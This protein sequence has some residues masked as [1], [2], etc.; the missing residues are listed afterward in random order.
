MI[1]AVRI[2]DH[3]LVG[4]AELY[5]G[6][7]WINDRTGVT[8]CLGGVHPGRGTCNALLSLG[9]K[10]Y[11]EI[12]VPDPE[13]ESNHFT[14][15]LRSLK[16]PTLIT[17]AAATDSI[18]DVETMARD[19]GFHPESPRDGS[20]A[21]PDGKLLQWKSISING[22]F[23]SRF[24]EP[25]PFFIQ[26]LPGSSHP[27]QD[28]PAGCRLESLEFEDPDSSPL[29]A[30]LRWLGIEATVTQ[31]PERRLRATLTTPLGKLSL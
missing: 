23:G 9:E 18:K 1:P 24:V 7:E 16:Q 17:W 4:A 22:A 21:R 13:Q 12:I 29:T 20:R 8:A 31:R 26:W 25:I 2:V 11:L 27:S 30:E 6:I 14:T 5:Q 28:S 3:L 19:A 10:Q 15:A